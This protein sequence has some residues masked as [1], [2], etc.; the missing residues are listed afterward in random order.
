MP[1]WQGTIEAT[2]EFLIHEGKEPEQ[3]AAIAHELAE[4]AGSTKA[5]MG[6]LKSRAGVQ[7][8]KDD[9]LLSAHKRTHAWFDSEKD[10]SSVVEQHRWLVSEMVDRSIEHKLYD[11]LDQE[12]HRAEQRTLAAKA[13]EHN[14]KTNPGVMVAWMVPKDLAK[15]IAVD[16]GEPADQLHVTLAYLGRREDLTDGQVETVTK[17]IAELAADTPSLRG[18]F[19]GLGRMSPG[20]EMDDVIYAVPDVPG[21]VE[22]RQSVVSAL[23]KA[24]VPAKKTHD[25]MPHVSLNFV[26]TSSE[27]P[28]MPESLRGT[29]IVMTA[30][31]VAQGLDRTVLEM[32][33]ALA[34]EK[35]NWIVKRSTESQYTLSVAY[36]VD[37]LDKHGEFMNADDLEEAAWRYM[38][39]SRRVGIMHEGRGD[40]G[41]AGAGVVV[42]SYLYRGPDWKINGEIVREGDWLVG[43]TW[44]DPAW[45]HIKAGNYTGLSFQGLVSRSSAERPARAPPE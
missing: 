2:I 17:A 1:A 8:L 12:A 32:A 43:I 30:L 6:A 9:V 37:Q 44:D 27:T 45:Q 35:N 16:G 40:D 7:K 36:P 15:E 38:T 5:V 34:T 22:L 41:S 29:P 42:E 26:D 4:Q 10:S 28:A 14:D 18:R 11:E 39:G 23:E 13:A 31:T 25:W 20:D 19:Q 33:P 3:A 24:G 21:L